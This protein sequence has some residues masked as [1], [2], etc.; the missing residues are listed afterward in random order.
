MKTDRFDKPSTSYKPS[1]QVEYV[2]VYRVEK[3]G[4]GPFQTNSHGEFMCNHLPTPYHDSGLPEMDE[5][6]IER[7]RFGAPTE[8]AL[9]EWVKR[10][11]MLDKLGYKVSLYKVKEGYVHSSD[12]QS[13][14]IK[15]HA[16]KVMEWGVQEFMKE[17]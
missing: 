5:D 11:K 2:N 15:R 8:E 3:R 6:E 1:K 17:C 7:F 10:P 4:R 14:F 13:M 12:I 9:K 16:K